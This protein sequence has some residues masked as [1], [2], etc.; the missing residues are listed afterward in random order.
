M[1]AIS[2]CSESDKDIILDL[3]AYYTADEEETI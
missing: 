3:T 2:K 1:G